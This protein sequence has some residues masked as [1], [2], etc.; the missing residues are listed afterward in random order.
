MDPES[1]D[2]TVVGHVERRSL[3]PTGSREAYSRQ[4]FS[5]VE[6]AGDEVREKLAG[7]EYVG[8]FVDSLLDGLRERDRTCMNLY[9]KLMK[10]VDAERTLVVE[11]WQR[12]G[13]RDAGEAQVLVERAK[14]AGS[15]TPREA[16]ET[17]GRYAEAYLRNNPGERAAWASRFGMSVESSRERV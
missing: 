17:C 6:A 5:L 12:L 4:I 14:S 11:I 10:M 15:Q 2:E 1:G 3:L 13:V 8:A 7:P 16:M 9:P